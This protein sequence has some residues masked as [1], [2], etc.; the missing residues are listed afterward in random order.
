MKEDWIAKANGMLPTPFSDLFSGE[1]DPQ[2]QRMCMDTKLLDAV[3]EMGLAAYNRKGGEDPFKD[4]NDIDMM[5][6]RGLQKF[7]HVAM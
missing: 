1:L 4:P 5:V 2:S 6:P 3:F 7:I